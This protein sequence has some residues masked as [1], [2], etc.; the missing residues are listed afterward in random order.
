MGL[1]KDIGL[2]CMKLRYMK[3]IL[4]ISPK[5]GQREFIILVNED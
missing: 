2:K 5:V 4:G 1:F 3:L